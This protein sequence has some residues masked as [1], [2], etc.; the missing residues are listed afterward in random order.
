MLKEKGD[1]VGER[2]NLVPKPSWETKIIATKDHQNL[3][4]SLFTNRGKQ[5]KVLFVASLKDRH[6]AATERTSKQPKR[7]RALW[8]TIQVH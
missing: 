7:N 1:R 4:G 5:G 6:K 8:M 3:P 2:R